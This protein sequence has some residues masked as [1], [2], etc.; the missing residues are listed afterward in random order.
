[1]LLDELCCLILPK[2]K[3]KNYEIDLIIKILKKS[4]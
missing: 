3:S 4:S 1:M 2:D